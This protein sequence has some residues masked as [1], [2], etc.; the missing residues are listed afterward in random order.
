MIGEQFVSEAGEAGLWRDI[1][2]AF[3]SRWCQKHMNAGAD[4]PFR[5]ADAGVMQL[6]D[7]MNAAS[8]TA[9]PRRLAFNVTLALGVPA[10]REALFEYAR[11]GW[12]TKNAH[13]MYEIGTEAVLVSDDGLHWTV[14]TLNSGGSAGWGWRELRDSEGT[15]ANIR[16]AIETNESTILL[17]YLPNLD[18]NDL[19]AE[20]TAA[21]MQMLEDAAVSKEP[22]YADG[23]DQLYR[24][25]YMLWGL[26]RA[27]GAFAELYLDGPESILARQQ[28][29]D[30]AAFAAALAEM[31]ARMQT[32]VRGVMKDG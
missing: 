8:L 19:T 11:M 22:V 25:L 18:W 9:S 15:A 12:A 30:P 2:E 17:R 32:L 16:F 3:A 31:D 1:P 6:A 13:G 26:K 14:E 28:R 10:E 27:D 29:A 7:C 21:A 23:R 20:E 5:C 4:N 24:D